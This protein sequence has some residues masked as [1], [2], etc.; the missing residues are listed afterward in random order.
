MAIGRTDERQNP[1]QS[2]AVN[3][4]HAVWM[5]LADPIW[6]SGNGSASKAGHMTAFEP[7]PGSCR[8]TLNSAGRPHMIVEGDNPFSRARQV[9]DDEADAGIKLAGVPLDLGHHPARTLPALRLLAEVGVVPSDLARR[10][11]NRALEQVAYP[12]LKNLIGR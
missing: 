7:Q 1:L 6:A 11:P 5:S 10:T 4:R 12:L 3:G 2:T 8:T 9:G